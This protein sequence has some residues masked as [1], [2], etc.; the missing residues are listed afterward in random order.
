M[1]I[2]MAKMM[3]RLRVGT[4]AIELA[5]RRKTPKR[6]DKC[7]NFELHPPTIVAKRKITHFHY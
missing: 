3:G 7:E 5:I 6:I 1:E 4:S 2:L